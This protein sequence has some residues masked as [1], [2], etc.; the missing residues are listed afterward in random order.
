M[1]GWFDTPQ[2]ENVVITFNIGKRLDLYYILNQIPPSLVEYR[3]RLFPGIHIR[4]KEGTVTLFKTGKGNCTAHSV[5]RANKAIDWV[6]SQIDIPKRNVERRITNVVC[7]ARLSEKVGCGILS[8]IFLDARTSKF[9]GGSTNIKV[10]T[11]TVRV[12][13][14]GR[15]VG[16]GFKTEEEAIESLNYVI[17]KTL[18][19]IR[20]YDEV[21]SA[22]CKLE[23]Y[24][25]TVEALEHIISHPDLE[26]TVTEKSAMFEKAKNIVV[27]YCEKT[28][29]ESF[30]HEPK[31]I[32]TGA[33]YITCILLNK[34]ITQGEIAIIG[35]RTVATVREAYLTIKRKLGSSALWEL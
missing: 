25:P 32:A 35:K 19:G 12:F 14:T 2:V 34:R 30:H 6:L 20:D 23:R 8:R 7:M 21:R 29:R 3:P 22:R 26:L 27:E 16:A 11:G 24:D 15:V 13:S 17:N 10:K 1:E 18:N 33:I 31:S 4:L 5:E 9:A 28:Q